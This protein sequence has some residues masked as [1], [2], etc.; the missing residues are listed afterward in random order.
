M[1]NEQDYKSECKSFILV[2]FVII[3]IIWYYFKSLVKERKVNELD[4]L[5]KKIEENRKLDD[6]LKKKTRRTFTFIRLIVIILYFA[7]NII[8]S[9]FFCCCALFSNQCI[10]SLLNYNTIFF[11]VVSAF[12]FARFGSFNSYH[13]WWSRYETKIEVYIYRKSPDLQ[14][15]IKNDQIYKA[16]LESEIKSLEL[17]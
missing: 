7:I 14:N 2:I 16:Q 1:T 4:S 5:K 9:K 15:I 17:E 8:F 10:G 12:T 11:I 13:K 6:A 3:I